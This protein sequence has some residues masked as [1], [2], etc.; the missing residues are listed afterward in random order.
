MNI[1]VLHTVRPL[2]QISHCPFVRQP[3]IVLIIDNSTGSCDSSM[4]ET[5][6][7]RTTWS[8][9][10][11]LYRVSLG[12]LYLGYKRRSSGRRVVTILA[13]FGRNN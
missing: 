11:Q 13:D 2:L 10:A 5:T 6:K 9:I 4:K 7:L 12:C 3:E 1:N 8:Q